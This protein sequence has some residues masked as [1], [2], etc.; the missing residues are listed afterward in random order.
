MSS[1]TLSKEVL[2]SI[3]A[4]LRNRT[5]VGGDALPATRD[6]AAEL[7]VS[8]ELVASA[9][10]E[11]ETRGLLDH[12]F[13]RSRYMVTGGRPDSLEKKVAGFLRRLIGRGYSVE[14]IDEALR[15]ARATLEESAEP[16]S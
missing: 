14:S 8:H 7:G 6:L 5:F 9:Y 12:P 13:K 4:M 11:L 16:Q 15:T 10:R 3:E 1:P 2:D